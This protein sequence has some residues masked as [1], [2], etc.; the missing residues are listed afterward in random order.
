MSPTAVEDERGHRLHQQPLPQLRAPSYINTGSDFAAEP[1][2][3]NRT[4][5]GLIQNGRDELFNQGG[6]I[7]DGGK[8]STPR[9]VG[10]VD[11]ASRRGQIL[12]DRFLRV[13]FLS[14]L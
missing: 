3:I 8:N 13:A 5:S 9:A 1:R 4:H 12:R 10:F 7:V 6:S 2:G 11:P 14:Y